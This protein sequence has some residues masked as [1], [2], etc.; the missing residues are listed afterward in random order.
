MKRLF[1]FTLAETLIVMGI[2]G[3]VAALTLPNLNNSTGD[4]EKVVKVKKIYSNLQ[5]AM[6]RAQ[7]I[8]GPYDEWFGSDS[9]NE[10]KL[11]RFS[12]RFTESMKLSK[13]CS[14]NTTAGCMTTGAMKNI[15]GTNYYNFTLVSSS[16][17]AYQLADGTSL[18]ISYNKPD[19]RGDFKLYVDI[20][21]PTKGQFKYGV[22]VF[23][24]F[25]NTSNGLYYVDSNPLSHCR[26]HG[27][28]LDT[29]EAWIFKYDNMDYT[30]VDNSLKCPDGTTT[31]DGTT[32]TSCK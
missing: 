8:Y 18:L 10:A 23:E 26:G 5:D 30:K 17:Y 9:S 25:I 6:G 14:N 2:I 15:A 13:S 1:G 11:K 19:A 31:L 3:V 28:N 12:E 32:K 24:F 21:G 7:A 29:C 4:K 27:S 16:N 20:D 22:D